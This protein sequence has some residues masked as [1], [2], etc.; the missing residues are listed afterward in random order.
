MFI[1]ALGVGKILA[2]KDPHVVISDDSQSCRW[3]LD[4]MRFI[5]RVLDPAVW[6]T[7]CLELNGMPEV[8]T[9]AV[10]RTGEVLPRGSSRCTGRF[11]RSFDLGGAAILRNPPGKE[12]LG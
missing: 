7:L 3:G 4:G 10:V 9:A 2:T 8:P 1:G 11:E 6:L 12:L 5:V